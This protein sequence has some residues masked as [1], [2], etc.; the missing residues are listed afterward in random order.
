MDGWKSIGTG[1]YF[2]GGA[3][4]GGQMVD[5]RYLPRIDEG[6]ARFM[7][8]GAELYRIEHYVYIGGV[9][10]ETKT[11]IYKPDAPEWAAVK[12]KLESE[13]E[14]IM[15]ALGLPITAL[16]LLW[17]ADF[18]PVDNHVTPFVVGEFNCSCL[19][20]SGFLAARGKDMDAVKPEDAAAGQ[21]MCDLIGQKALAAVESF[22]K[23]SSGPVD[24]SAIP[25]V[26]KNDHGLL[27]QPV[28]PKYR[29][30]LVEIYVPSQPGGGSDKITNGHRFDSIPFANGMINAGMSC[31]LINYDKDRHDEFFK[32]LE[33]FDAIVVRCNP[34]QINAAGGD[35]QKF[36]N[37]M[38]KLAQTR[39][40][41]PTPDVMS[42]MG[43]KDALCMIKDMDFG[44]KDTL[45]YY[46]PADIS[47]G[48]RKTIAF[49]PR[50]VKQ[51]RGSAGEGIWIIKLNSGD[52]CANYGDR[53]V[54]DDEVLLL[55]EACDNHT[56]EHTVAE[57][58]EFCVNG[59]T[60]K[61]GEWKSIGTGK[62][63]E[64][65][66]AAGGQMVDQRY[67]P[68]IDEGEARF[69]MVGAELY[70]IEHYVYI[71]GVG[72]ETKTTIYQPDAPEWAAVKAKLESE[73]EKIMTALGLPITALPLLWAADF[74]PVD[75][76]VTPF[77]VGEF[78]CSCLG[79]SGFLAA[80]GKD[81]DAVSLADGIA[82]QA[83]CDLIG[84]KALAAVESFRKGSSGPVDVSAIPVVAKNDFGLLPQPVNPKFK[85]ALV[86]IY[87]PS[88]PG[89]GSD[90]ITNGH[91]FDSI[92]FANG[93][94]NAGM[95][96]QLV[97]YDKD[98]HDEFFKM[99]EQF[100]AI[101]VRCNPG[102]INAA[103]GDQRKF[104]DS[105]MK[106]AEKKPVWPTPD[107]MAKMG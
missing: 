105:M 58:I 98:K 17:A 66:R 103:G 22:R 87:V 95:S 7:M 27:P 100:D 44:L 41:W 6:E 65:G 84:Q 106:L 20:I 52:Y 13:V 25:V 5:Q 15:T 86:E 91:R 102:Q 90:K 53:E 46:E 10:G 63:F 92:P 16:P 33:Q 57:F 37:S 96:C 40:V 8:V 107:V 23:G 79:I 19:G 36:D 72:G 55:T 18:I 48:F 69:M 60:G 74:I 26:A 68:R 99:L 12:A 61:S 85:T 97:N 81:M 9:G 3:A 29:T 14:K 34:G 62:Y 4:A 32:M 54:A 56:E 49:Q 77:V 51:N 43:A 76:H 28:H 38:M 45:G 80:R 11:T 59:R 94:I 71:G 88:Q 47:A 89:G 50:V 82:G 31:Q 101:V 1:K 24:V 83:M 21:A 67:L 73:V 104:D 35:Q 39:P 64:G 70:R 75:N 78:N 2:E 30:A 93:M 42:K